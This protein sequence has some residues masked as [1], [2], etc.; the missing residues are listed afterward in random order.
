MPSSQSD[1]GNSSIEGPS[2]QICVKLVKA[3]KQKFKQQKTTLFKVRHKAGQ[4]IHCLT[5]QVRNRVLPSMALQWMRSEMACLFP[6]VAVISAVC[7]FY[8]KSEMRKVQLGGTY[9]NLNMWEIET[10]GD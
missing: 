2:S 10:G 9:L 8:Y 3:N 4:A 6:C 5:T 7:I 1:G